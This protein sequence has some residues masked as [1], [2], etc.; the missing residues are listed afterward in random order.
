MIYFVLKMVLKY[1]MV[2]KSMK[3]LEMGISDP[4]VV[5]CKIK[6]LRA[7]VE[8]NEKSKD[9]LRNLEWE[10]KWTGYTEKYVIALVT[11]LLKVNK[12]K[13]SK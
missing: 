5:L 6:F 11:N 10:V 4:Y 3:V 13:L 8:M 12:V 9:G 2:V 1:V 7:Q